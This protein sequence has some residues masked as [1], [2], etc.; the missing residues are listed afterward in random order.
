MEWFIALS[1]LCLLPALAAAQVRFVDATRSAGIDLH[2]RHGGTGEKYPMETMG[3]G[4][5]FFDLTPYRPYQ[6]SGA[7]V[8]LGAP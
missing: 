2:H 8:L 5:V 7:Q 3:S 6:S 4:A 1:A